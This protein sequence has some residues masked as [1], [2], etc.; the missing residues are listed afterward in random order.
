MPRRWSFKHELGVLWGNKHLWIY[1]ACCYHLVE[2]VLH[3]L[4]CD[5][6]FFLLGPAEVC[7]PQGKTVRNEY[8]E[9]SNVKSQP[10]VVDYC[11][12]HASF[13]SE[14]DQLCPHHQSDNSEVRN[15]NGHSTLP[16]QASAVD[17]VQ[18]Q[19]KEDE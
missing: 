16:Q 7:S 2:L 10:P 15:A 9:N 1:L 5:C 18:E 12:P 11:N 4:L 14:E 17:V 8:I 3:C 19:E 13:S 6:F